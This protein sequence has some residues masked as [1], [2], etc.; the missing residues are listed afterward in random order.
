MHFK[1]FIELSSGDLA[2]ILG[3]KIEIYTKSLEDKFIIKSVLSDINSLKL[4][5]EKNEELYSIIKSYFKSSLYFN[6][7]FIIVK[8][9]K[10]DYPNIKE[11]IQ[12]QG[13]RI[14]YHEFFEEEILDINEKIY[15]ITKKLDGTYLM[16]GKKNHIFQIYFDKYGFPE[17]LS[18]VDTGYGVKEDDCEGDCIYSYSGSSYYSVGLIEECENGDIVTISCLDSLKK[19]WRYKK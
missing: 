7:K 3:D 15:S 13:S 4:F 14:I 1:N 2:F 9:Y 16:G 5:Y 19:F 17:V 6:E 8:G 10:G 12:F 18:E 11:N